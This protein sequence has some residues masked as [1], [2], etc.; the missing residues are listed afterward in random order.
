MNEGNWPTGEGVDEEV[1]AI[2]AVILFLA[3]AYAHAG[4]ITIGVWNTI[5]IIAILSII[6][7]AS[8][9]YGRSYDMELIIPVSILEGIA[10]MVIA[11]WLFVIQIDPTS[12]LLILLCLVVGLALILAQKLFLIF[13]RDQN[14]NISN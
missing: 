6:L 10:I 5:L 9:L 1:G 7:Y 13:A 14:K 2:F 4:I 8:M 12:H 11:D 3:C